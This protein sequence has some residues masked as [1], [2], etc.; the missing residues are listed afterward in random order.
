M[1]TQA[2]VLGPHATWNGSTR[3][4][5]TPVSPLFAGW[6][7]TSPCRSGTFTRLIQKPIFLR[8][9]GR[10]RDGQQPVRQARVWIT[11]TVS[12]EPPGC[13]TKTDEG[14]LMTL[15]VAHPRLLALSATEGQRAT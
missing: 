7:T 12:G 5:R 3:V 13:Q 10:V 2:L 4:I 1:R 11:Q 8:D 6:A 14:A 15:S 9:T